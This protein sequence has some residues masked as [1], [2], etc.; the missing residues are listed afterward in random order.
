MTIENLKEKSRASLKTILRALQYRNYRLFFGGQIISLT[1]RWMQQVAISWLVY[2]LTNDAFL[3]GVVGFSSQIPTFL[4]SPFAGVIA[5][6]INRNKI[7]IA[8]QTLSMLQAFGLV[9]LF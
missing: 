5:D 9:F 1:G 4:I 2:R 6:R 8:T 3:L 7:L